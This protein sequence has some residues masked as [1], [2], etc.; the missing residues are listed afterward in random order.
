MGGNLF[1][2]SIPRELG[3]LTGL[4]IALNLSYNKLTGEIPPELSN[5]VMLE[6]LLLNNNNL[7]GEIPSSFANLSSLLGYNFSYNSLTGPIPLLRNIS[8]SSFIGNEGL[9]GPPL[10]QCIQTQPFAPSQSTGK[11][12]G[13]RSSKI[14][15]ITAAVIGGVSLMLI[16]LIVYLMRRPVRTVASSAQ[17]GQPSEMSL[18][19]YFPPKEGFTFQDL[20]AA[21]D[22]F[23]E[24]FVVGRGACGTVYKAV[25]PAGYTLAVKKLASNHEG[26]NNNNVDNSFRAEILTLGNIRHRNIVKLHGFCN[27]QGSN[28][29]LYEYMP[30]GSLGEILHDPSCNLDWSKRFKIALGAAQG[31]AYLHHDCKPRIFHRDIKSNNILLD[32]KFEAHVGDFG[33]A[34]VID[35]PHSKSMSA[36]AGSYGYIAPEYAYT[37]KVTEKSDIYSYGVVLLELLT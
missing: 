4:Q 34:K 14:I 11:P 10:N 18:D 8:M 7:S 1:N 25:L 5:L 20:V 19:I 17:D 2:G 33:L 37:M 16:A 3:S 28:L 32:D 23:D 35:M 21:T 6:F 24:S 27:H 15:A 26:G 30:K 31:L 29:L 36:I 12:G 9:C 22:N 13:M